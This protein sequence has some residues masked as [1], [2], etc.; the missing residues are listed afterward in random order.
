SQDA[1]SREFARE[2]SDRLWKQLVLSPEAKSNIKSGIGKEVLIVFGLAI[3][4][5]LSFKLPVLFGV[6]LYGEAGNE[7]FYLRNFSL[8]VLPYL[9]IYFIWKR[10]I[11]ASYYKWLSFPFIA[12]VI[13]ANVYPFKQ[14]GSNEFLTSLHLPIALWLAIGAAYTGGQWKSSQRRM[15]FVRFSGELFIYYSLIAFGGGVLTAFTINIFSFIGI[16][17][18]RF[19]GQWIVPCGALGAVIIGSW[20]VEAKQSVIENM[21]PVL[22][23]IFTPLFVILLLSFLATMIITGNGLQVEREVLIGFDLLLVLVLGLLLY[24]ASARDPLAKP[25]LFDVTQMVLIVSAL[26]I[27]LVALTAIAWRISEFGFS[28]NKVAALGENI[29]LL[30]NLA[31][32]A[33]LYFYFMRGRNPFNTLERWQTDYL[34]IYGI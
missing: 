11:N 10:Q 17:L 19:A 8:F 7:S 9:A 27:D 6:Q 1:L 20:L 26:I 15:D 21:A 32:S 29:I 16:D 5:A 4:A 3:A 33:R 31:W 22:T 34:P 13:F 18:G 30:V 25:D 28:P 14:D 24:S 2:H 12:A 23:R